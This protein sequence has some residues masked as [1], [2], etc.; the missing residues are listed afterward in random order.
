MLGTH[1]ILGRKGRLVFDY[2]FLNLEEWIKNKLV[3]TGKEIELVISYHAGYLIQVWEDEKVI[4]VFEGMIY[5]QSEEYIHSFCL[6][7]HTLFYQNTEQGKKKL[8]DF[9]DTADGD[10]IISIYNKIT[11]DFLVFND[12][13]GRL[14]V[15]FHY[16]DKGLILSRTL[17]FILQCL[18]EIR[19]DKWGIIEKIMFDYNL[20]E[21]TLFEGIK[22]LSAGSYIYCCKQ[23]DRFQIIVE[24]ALDKNYILTSSFR[25]KEE[26]L[27][28]LVNIFIKGVELRVKKLVE[29]KFDI[30]NTLSGGYDSR[31]VF[32]ALT[33]HA[34]TI[35]VHYVTFEYIQDESIIAKKLYEQ[36][37]FPGN[38]IKLSFHNE[39]IK[40]NL[41]SLL[42]KTDGRVG[43]YTTAVC[44]N[45]HNYMHNYLQF[46]RTALWGGFG[47]EFIRHP[48][49]RVYL[50]VLQSVRLG[51]YNF[52]FV[53]CKSLFS[54]LFDETN[55]KQLE[56]YFA[57]YK[58]K[59]GEDSLKHFYNEY[60]RNL[61]VCSGEDRGRIFA[62]S[63]HPMM[64]LDFI[65]LVRQR[66]P[67]EWANFSF[68]ISFMKLVD[69]RLLKIPIYGSSVD[70]QSQ[71]SIIDF[72]KEYN[73]KNN[74]ITFKQFL[75]YTA[76]QYVP[77]LK[78]SYNA[79]KVKKNGSL[80]TQFDNYYNSL[81]VCKQLFNK[82]QVDKRISLFGNS[83]NRLLSLVMY[84]SEI[85][86]RYSTKLKVD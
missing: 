67:L 54:G 36:L 49:K 25:N 68:F 55:E 21:H 42:Y 57:N 4:V 86:K 83:N 64:T 9:I 32:G 59:K 31:V 60:Y 16:D 78:K 40:T 34:E 6:Y 84:L 52:P 23:N 77:F 65:K 18:P 12:Y 56:K 8:G 24:E 37:G 7:I 47:G 75:K 43:Y 53:E 44:Y 29:K 50:S 13:L 28:D 81:T 73:R 76:K 66:L 20:G 30:I 41:S 27:Y 63:V 70:L 62:W 5:N 11:G 51:L 14:P 3:Y 79:N 74:E 48:L 58:E 10:Y 69:E 80:N 45:D 46:D 26:A 85:E 38:Y 71:E 35:D 61:V 2:N 22:L 19:F 17:K 72:D 15:F 33:K 1:C 82:E 39:V